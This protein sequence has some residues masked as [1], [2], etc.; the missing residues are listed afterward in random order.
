[1]TTQTHSDESQEIETTQSADPEKMSFQEFVAMRR[2]EK[3]KT[4]GTQSAPVDATVQKHSPESEPE[5]KEAKDES[6]DESESDEDAEE[7]TE[8]EKDKPKKKGGFQRR[9]DKLNSRAAAEKARADALEARLAE[10]EKAGK[11]KRDPE[12]KAAAAEGEP[13]PEDFDTHAAYVKAQARWEAKQLLKEER[14]EAEK[15]RFESDQQKVLKAHAERVKSFSEK[16]EDF[17]DVLESVD[18]I[19]VS[20]AVREVILESEHGPALMYE[21]AKNRDEYARICELSDRAAARELGKIEAK[22]EA[23]ASQEK[24]PEPKITKAPKPIGP[25]GG[26]KG[27]VAKSIDD[28]NLSFSDYERMR[29]EQLKRKR[30]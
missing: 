16:T 30:G 14:Q 24:K 20:A 26:G 18:D 5:E 12:P 10:L 2:G 17:A 6:L 11:S 28:P 8:S 9:I 23:R 22:I 15:I 1:M 13:Q 25:I 27:T 4:E 3:P 29:R 19:P 21:L 7:S